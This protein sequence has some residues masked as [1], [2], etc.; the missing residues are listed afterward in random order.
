MAKPLIGRKV[1]HNFAVSNI[2]NSITSYYYA[3]TNRIFDP[4]FVNNNGK[5]EKK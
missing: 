3:N 2:S 4:F 1:I 5:P